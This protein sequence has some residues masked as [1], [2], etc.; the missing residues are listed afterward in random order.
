M[1]SEHVRV[2]SAQLVEAYRS[3]QVSPV[4]VVTRAL[5][6]A[7]ESERLEPS[8]G[9]FVC[10]NEPE[11]LRQ[12]EASAARYAAG[13]PRSA[14]DGVPVAIKDE[15]DIKGYPM[16][17]G[18]RF[19]PRTPASE[20]APVVERLRAA[21]AVLFGKTSLH[22]IGFG[23]TGINPGHITA[24][25]PYRTTHM[26]GGSSSG[27]GAV[28]SAGICPVA[29]GSDA[30]GSIRIPASFCGVYGIKPTFGLLPAA[31]GALLSCSMDHLGPLG[32]S[33]DDLARFVD[34]TAGPH[35]D[36]PASMHQGPYI[37]CAGVAPRALDGL[38][39]AWSQDYLEQAELPVR[40]AFEQLLNRLRDAG[41]T[42]TQVKLPLAHIIQ[43]VGYITMASE[44]ASAQ[45]DH[46]VEH[47]HLYNL[48]T[49][50]LL[51]VGARITAE[52]Y[53]HAQRLRTLIKR[54]FDD[55]FDAHDVF[56]CPSTAGHARRIS[57]E[58]LEAGEVNL[59]INEIVSAFTFAANLT[60]TPALSIPLGMTSWDLPLGLQLMGPAWSEPELFAIAHA[61]DPLCEPVSAPAVSYRV[62]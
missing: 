19:R 34:I 47:R 2:T 55:V 24:R 7:H 4:D 54:M 18:T 28:V 62:L 5:E 22:E 15:F 61:I 53:L 11:I 20:D 40:S 60:G 9:G 48:D 36:D 30:G 59:R 52:E 21:G 35:P 37:P 31:G 1:S 8:L 6:A 25:N 33:L 50:L 26:T 27:S 45:R 10:R 57:P 43:R 56:L 51:A 17:A 29:L 16:T 41:A 14:L 23:G 12:A 49:R 3:G 44:A 42:V 38:R 13:A 46:L 39:V 32:A 58:A